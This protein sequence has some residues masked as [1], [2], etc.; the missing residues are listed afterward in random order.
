MA[1][2]TKFGNLIKELFNQSSTVQT[3]LEDDKN[4]QAFEAGPL[5]T[6]NA[7]EALDL[8]GLSHQEHEEEEEPE[9]PNDTYFDDLENQNN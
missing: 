6:Q 1:F 7:I 5:T 9:E 2:V 3:I 8:R 4:W